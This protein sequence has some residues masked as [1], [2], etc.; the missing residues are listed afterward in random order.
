AGLRRVG[1]ASIRFAPHGSW[2]SLCGHRVM[3]IPK[4]YADEAHPGTSGCQERTSVHRL[5]CSKTHGRQDRWSNVND[6]WP[7]CLDSLWRVIDVKRG[8]ILSMH[9]REYF[10]VHQ[11]SLV[12]RALKVIAVDALNAEIGRSSNAGPRIQTVP[13]VNGL[14]HRNTVVGDLGQAAPDL[15]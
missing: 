8:V 3:V 12:H 14:D 1:S 2:N 11:L 5:R 10:A 9:A 15:V 7:G 4:R 6:V 13:V